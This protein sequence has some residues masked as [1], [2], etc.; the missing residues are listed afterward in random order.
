M[1]VLWSFV[2]RVTTAYM[3]G[4]EGEETPPPHP[5]KEKKKKRQKDKKDNNKQT[6][7]EEEGLEKPRNENNA[8]GDSEH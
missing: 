3:T 4:R 5:K 7:I 1:A 6:K 2:Q 8:V